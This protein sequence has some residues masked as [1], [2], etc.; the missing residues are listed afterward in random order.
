MQIVSLLSIISTNIIIVSLSRIII[1][2]YLRNNN[3]II[4][5][6]CYLSL[7]I[8]IVICIVIYK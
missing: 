6:Y 5:M 4:I 3:I 7:F 2:R 8:S 1:Y